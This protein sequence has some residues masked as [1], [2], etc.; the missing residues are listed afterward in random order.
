[1]D[2]VLEILQKFFENRFVQSALVIVVGFLFYKLVSRFLLRQSRKTR[3]LRGGKGETYLRLTNSAMKYT[4][5]VLTVML[6][7]QVNH[8]NITSMVAGIGIVS[9]I[10]GLA[11]QDALQDI[12]RGFNI[13]SDEYFH[14]GDIVS[15]RE[16][17][18][19]VLELG[20]KTT[21]LRELKTNH[22]LSIPNRA[23]EEIRLLSDFLYL[24]IPLP[25]ELP[26]SDAERLMLM[27]VEACRND[28]LVKDITYL[29]VN[30]FADSSILYL[31]QVQCADTQYKYRIRRSCLHT[32]LEVLES[33]GVSVPYQQIDVHTK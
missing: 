4:V 29:G 9:I 19:K 26:L 14:V 12:I 25:Y 15:F 23:I 33:Q 3:L 7:L 17:E 32:V 11:V 5:L 8:I 22:I 30:Q 10:L 21:K 28:A 31:L 2:R 24:E 18:G 1:M 6:L 20:L 13:V 27:I 16:T